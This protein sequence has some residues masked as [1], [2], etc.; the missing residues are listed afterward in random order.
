[1]PGYSAVVDMALALLPWRYLL[2]QQMS[3]KEKIGVTVA[4]SMGVL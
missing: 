1:V 2:R 4:M 3:K